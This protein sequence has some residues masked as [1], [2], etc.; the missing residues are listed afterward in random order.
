MNRILACVLLSLG[1]VLVIY[2]F[3]ALPS[4]RAA[5]SVLLKG[6]PP[7]QD[8]WFFLGG[9]TTAV[10]G[11]VMLFRAPVYDLA[12]PGRYRSDGRSRS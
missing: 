7:S 3:F 2:G 6:G 10:T 11:L 12:K 1:S 8:L 5:L 9:V 4:L